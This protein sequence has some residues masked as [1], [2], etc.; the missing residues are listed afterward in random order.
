VVARIEDARPRRQQRPAAQRP[1][2]DDAASDMHLPAFLLRPVVRA[3][4]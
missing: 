3:K 4:A 2:R 1:A